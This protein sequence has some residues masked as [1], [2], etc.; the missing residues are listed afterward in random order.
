M[1]MDFSRLDKPWAYRILLAL[2]LLLAN[3]CCRADVEVSVSYYRDCE[4]KVDLKN[5]FEHDIELATISI[6]WLQNGVQLRAV[7][8]SIPYSEL[9]QVAAFDS[10]LDSIKILPG[11]SISGVRE[12]SGS[13]LNLCKTLKE[14]PVI[15]F[16]SYFPLIFNINQNL[17]K[18]QEGVV[19]I[20]K[21]P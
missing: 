4:L 19:L 13:F 12:L 15:I 18:F 20:P 1:K 9:N 6:P 21:N 7:P 8:V 11:Q 5:N 2:G 10:S 16:W 3:F 14:S 17:L